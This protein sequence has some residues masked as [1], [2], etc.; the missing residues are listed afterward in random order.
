MREFK[1]LQVPDLT[2]EVADKLEASLRT[3][4]GIKKFKITLRDQELYV[5]FDEQTLPFQTLAQILAEAGCPLRN[6]RAVFIQ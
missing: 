2:A 4:S 1:A 6:M 5:A 3:L